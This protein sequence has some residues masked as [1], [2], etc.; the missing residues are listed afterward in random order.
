MRVFRSAVMA[1][2]FRHA[3]NSPSFWTT[4]GHAKRSGRASTG[5]RWQTGSIVSAF[6]LSM[7]I[8]W[9]VPA[10]PMCGGRILAGGL[11][12]NPKNG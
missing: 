2:V 11:R 3:L 10:A 8:A 12:R 4:R 5:P 1:R 7:S 9:Q 6:R